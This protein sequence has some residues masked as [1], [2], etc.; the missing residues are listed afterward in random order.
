MQQHLCWSITS[1]QKVTPI[2]NSLGLD[3]FHLNTNMNDPLVINNAYIGKDGRAHLS[4]NGEGLPQYRRPESLEEL[5]NLPLGKAV[6]DAGDPMPEWLRTYMLL[7]STSVN[8]CD[9]YC[10]LAFRTKNPENKVVYLVSK[11]EFVIT[12]VCTYDD[13]GIIYTIQL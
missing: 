9:A 5:W 11:T 7:R 1:K 6:F 13:Y 2:E 4:M 3:Q 8:R 10:L 12:M